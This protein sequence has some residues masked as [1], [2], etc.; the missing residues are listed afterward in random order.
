MSRNSTK[1]KLPT[2]MWA[3]FTDGKMDTGAMLDAMHGAYGMLYPSRTA[4][5]RMYDDVR[6]V[7]IR[8][9]KK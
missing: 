2:R 1:R 8:E 9:V 5:K 7:E 4:A 6:R 3:G